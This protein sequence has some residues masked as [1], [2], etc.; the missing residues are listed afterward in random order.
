M[1]IVNAGQITIYEQIPKDLK[2][3]I[4]DVLFN[5]HLDATE[6]LIEISNKYS[7]SVERKKIDKKWRSKK[8]EKKIKDYF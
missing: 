6:N 3:C 7:G 5:K 4:E 8:L 1:A 2:K